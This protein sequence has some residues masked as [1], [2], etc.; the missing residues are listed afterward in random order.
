MTFDHIYIVVNFYCWKKHLV[1]SDFCFNLCSSSCLYFKLADLFILLSLSKVIGSTISEDNCLTL[2]K[3]TYVMP[4]VCSDFPISTH[5]WGKVNPWLLWI[6]S[7]HASLSG[8]C[9]LSWTELLN[10]QWNSSRGNSLFLLA[11][12]LRLICCAWNICTM[13]SVQNFKQHFGFEYPVSKNRKDSKW[14]LCVLSNLSRDARTFL[15]PMLF[16]NRFLD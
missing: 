5:A 13:F 1:V 14:S 12:C 2:L 3:A 4:S 6:V 15:L 8:S 7:A 16:L 10:W 11:A 9:C